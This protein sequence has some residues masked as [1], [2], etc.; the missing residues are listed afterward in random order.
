M[1]IMSVDLR[2]SDMDPPA[3][4]PRRTI[5]ADIVNLPDPARLGLVVR[6]FN[7]DEVALYTKVEGYNANWTFTTKTTSVIPSGTNAYFNLD[8]FGSRPKPGSETIE[9][10][11][12]TLKAYTDAGYTNLKWTFERNITVYFIKTDDGSWTLDELDNFDDGTVQGWGGFSVNMPPDYWGVVLDYVLSPPYSLR[13]G[14]HRVANSIWVYMSKT[15]NTPDRENVFAV[16]DLRF[17]HEYGSAWKNT[18]TVQIDGVTVLRTGS[19]SAWYSVTTPW[20]RWLRF[21]VPLPSNSTPE[22]I[23]RSDGYSNGYPWVIYQ[24][25]DDFQIISKN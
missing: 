23:L 22:I 17:G 1:S 21:V 24:W 5:Y 4:E 16:A 25:L 12:V 3:R 20:D 8:R 19:T 13:I 11:T 18:F 2:F 10:I 14:E 6:I 15:F 7:Y 9:I